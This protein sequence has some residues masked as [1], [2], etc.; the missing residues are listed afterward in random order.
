[1]KERRLVK[2]SQSV[3]VILLSIIV[4]SGCRDIGRLFG[5]NSAVISHENAMQ[6]FEVAGEFLDIAEERQSL[7]LYCRASEGFAGCYLVE[8]VRFL[9]WDGLSFNPDI[10][11]PDHRTD[12]QLALQILA[13]IGGRRIDSAHR[14][15]VRVRCERPTSTPDQISCWIDYGHG[16][17]WEV[18]PVV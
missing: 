7:Y 4:L 2:F 17:G 3:A 8:P 14:A 18:L 9:E 1:M 13:D 12:R 6:V 16:N 11:N 5:G 15:G 10:E